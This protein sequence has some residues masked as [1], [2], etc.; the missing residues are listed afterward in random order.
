MTARRDRNV[1]VELAKVALLWAAVPLLIALAL[2]KDLAE[3][4]WELHGPGP[5]GG[6]EEST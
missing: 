1:L 6:R 2:A 4:L 3:A 5:C